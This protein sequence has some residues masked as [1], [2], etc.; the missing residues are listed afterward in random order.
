MV[1][2]YQ[3]Y[4]LYKN[5]KKMWNSKRFNTAVFNDFFEDTLENYVI[6]QFINDSPRVEYMSNYAIKLVNEINCGLTDIEHWLM[7]VL[8]K[9]LCDKKCP[10]M[11]EIN[12]INKLKDN[13]I[14]KKRPIINSQIKLVQSLIAEKGSGLNEFMDTKFSLYDLDD[15]QENQA[16]KMYSMS[17]L[18][19]EFYIQGFKAGKFKI[20]MD[21]IKSIDYKRFITFTKMILKLNQEISDKNVNR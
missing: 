9:C 13:M 8:M 14:F 1:D 3:V 16:Y 10:E 21:K 5:V 17:Q 7:Y 18:D 11:P 20:D 2:K 6:S 12:S 15:N 19:P 4:M